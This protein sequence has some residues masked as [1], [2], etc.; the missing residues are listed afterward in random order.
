[1]KFGSFNLLEPLERFQACTGIALTLP[2]TEEKGCVAR[3]ALLP[4]QIPDQRYS[5]FND[6]KN[7]KWEVKLQAR[8]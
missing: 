6:T 7:F 3:A 2:F 5:Q 4:H 8:K 1:L